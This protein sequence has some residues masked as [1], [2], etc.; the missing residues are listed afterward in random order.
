MMGRVLKKVSWDRTSYVLSSKAYFGSRGKGKQT[1]SNRVE[2]ETPG[3]GMQ[4]GL[5]AFTGGYLDLFFCHRPDKTVPIEEV[6]WTMNLLIQQGKILYWGTSEWSGVE[7][8]E[9]HR[10]AQ[11]YH[12]IGPGHGAA[13]I[14]HV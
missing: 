9:A 2:Q 6:V 14:Q 11:H 3:R 4:R 10:V 5:A 12:L 1:Q 7:I 13:S 8:M